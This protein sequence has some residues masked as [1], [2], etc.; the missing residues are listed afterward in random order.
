M[1]ILKH[2]IIIFLSISFLLYHNYNIKL[3]IEN[4]TPKTNESTS[5][6]FQEKRIY[7]SPNYRMK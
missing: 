4:T 2:T 7:P 5:I 1:N 3:D 6:P